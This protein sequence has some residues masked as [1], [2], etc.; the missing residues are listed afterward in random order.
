MNEEQLQQGR[1]A[2][3]AIG[4]ESESIDAFASTTC[5]NEIKKEIAGGLLPYL[6]SVIDNLKRLDGELSS[7]VNH[8]EEYTNEKT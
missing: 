3:I 6:H 2:L 5:H 7:L 4:W 8:I 1:D